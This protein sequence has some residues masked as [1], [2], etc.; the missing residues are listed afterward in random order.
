MT[1]FNEVFGNEKA[2]IASM[3]LPP[4]PGSPDYKSGT[5]LEEI[6]NYTH[7]E[8]TNLQEGG[9]DGVFADDQVIGLWG[10]GFNIKATDRH[11]QAGGGV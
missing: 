8:L 5:S 11:R 3:Y 1:W 2:I 7:N 4:L 10:I 6:I 9:M